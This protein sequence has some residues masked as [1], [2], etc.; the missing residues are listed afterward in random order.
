MTSQPLQI[1]I[2]GAG[3]GGLGAGIALAQRGFSVEIVEAKPDATVFGVGINQPANSLRALRSLGVLDQVRDAGFEFDRSTLFDYRGRQVVEVHPEREADVPANVALS[4]Q[5]LSDILVARATELGIPIRY[6]TAVTGIR[7]DVDQARVSLADGTELGADLV[8]AFDGTHSKTRGA[9]FPDLAAA[10]FTGYSIWRLTVPR[11]A[12]VTTSRLFQG[13]GTKAGVIPLSKESMYLLHVTAEPGRPRFAQEDFDTL[14]VERL[15]GYE[16]LI[17]EI[18]DAISSPTGIVYSPL[19]VTEVPAPWHRGRIVLLG[20]AA[21][22]GAPHLTQ[23]AGMAL[24]DGVVLA[25][26]L[27]EEPLDLERTLNRFVARRLPR[28]AFV[29]K[30]SADI[31]LREMAVTADTLDEALSAAAVN[32]PVGMAKISS[33]LDQP[34]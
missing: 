6:G 22:A 19:D 13:L 4:R 16:G 15:E 1:V 31:L 34:A 7:D 30:A 10:T 26:M 29:Q 23:G 14:L 25:E 33:Y 11:P 17:G 24:E 32:T 21:H 2:V 18:R 8:L 27:A 12:E 5:D 3:I 9:L 20:D 28:T